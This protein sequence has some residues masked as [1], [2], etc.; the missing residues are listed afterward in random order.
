MPSMWRTAVLPQVDRL[1][2]AEKQGS[3][4]DRNRLRRPRQRRADVARHV[5]R[6]F[7]VVLIVPVFGRD[8]FGPPLQIPQHRGI[9][10]LLHDERRAR[11]LYE[12]GAKAHL[13]AGAGHS[14][15]DLPGHVVQPA[16][17]GAHLDFFLMHLHER[18]LQRPRSVRSHPRLRRLS[19]YG[20]RRASPF[21]V[22]RSALRS[23][24]SKASLNASRSSGL[25]LV[26]QFWSMTTGWRF[27]FAPACPRPPFT[28]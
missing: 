6:T 27:T 7:G 3:V 8:P 12:H 20:L 19:G 21:A 9:R 13:H 23:A 10:V 24:W 22:A 14:A 15:T 1:P 18:T 28:V 16:P 17:A 11:V 4:A 26:I 2:G 5:V 25:R